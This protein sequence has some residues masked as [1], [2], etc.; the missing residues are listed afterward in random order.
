MVQSCQG[1]EFLDVLLEAFDDEN[2]DLSDDKEIMKHLVKIF[3]DPKCSGRR[4]K[5][6]LGLTSHDELQLAWVRSIGIR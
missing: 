2:I 1:Y 4:R 5:E 3:S 6:L